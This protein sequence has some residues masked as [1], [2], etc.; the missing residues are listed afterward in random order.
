MHWKS[1]LLTALHTEYKSF[2]ELTKLLRRFYYL[3][4]IAGKT[5]SDVKHASFA[6]IKSLKDQE[7]IEKITKDIEVKLKNDNIEALSLGALMSENIASSHWCKPLL[8]LAEY[9]ASDDSKLSFIDLNQDLHLEHILPVKYSKFKEWS[10]INGEIAKKWINSAGNLTLLSGAKNIEASNNPFDI[11][12]GVYK[13]K[14]KY[15]DKNAKITAFL[16]TQQIVYDYEQSTY[17]QQWTISAI[18][19][20]WG[21]FFSEVGELLDIDVGDALEK[22]EPILN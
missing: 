8:L 4:W 1:I 13:G 20:R 15:D 10:H 5:L 6:I 7:S 19:N 12:M 14:G 17:A 3:Y 21:W 16:I 22:H 2:N 18:V 9:N 11:K